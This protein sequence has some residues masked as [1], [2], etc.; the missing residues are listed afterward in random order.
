[1]AGRMGW[2]GC[3]SATNDLSHFLSHELL[4]DH[5]T[6]ID[7]KFQGCVGSWQHVLT[8]G[9][10]ASGLAA[11]PPRASSDDWMNEAET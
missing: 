6:Q 5:Q 8:G 1:V 10:M 3:W 11:R 2:I 4:A 9:N 7:R